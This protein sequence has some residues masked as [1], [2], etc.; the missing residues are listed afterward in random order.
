MYLSIHSKFESTSVSAAFKQD[1]TSSVSPPLNDSNST[2]K[3]DVKNNVQFSSSS[4]FFIRENIMRAEILRSLH[5]FYKHYSYR[6]CSEI[7]QFFQ[8]MFPDMPRI[9]AKMLYH[10]KKQ[11]KGAKMPAAGK[12]FSHLHCDFQLFVIGLS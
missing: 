9:N 3:H 12:F 5:V 2:A 7:G 1:D 10:E 6:S 11:A 4:T 8:K